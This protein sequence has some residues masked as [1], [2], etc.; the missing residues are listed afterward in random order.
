MG[1]KK[2]TIRKKNKQGGGKWG[3]AAGQKRARFQAF[4]QQKYEMDLESKSEKW[5]TRDLPEWEIGRK[6][7]FWVTTEFA[8]RPAGSKGPPKKTWGGKGKKKPLN[9][10]MIC[11]RGSRCE[12]GAPTRD[13]S[14]VVRI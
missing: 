8:A 6:R 11:E 9:P 12:Q 1:E 3:K 10:P 5:R 2:K 7:S 4:I 14:A 13:G